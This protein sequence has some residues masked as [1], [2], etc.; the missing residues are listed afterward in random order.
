MMADNLFI[1]FD[2]F[3]NFFSTSER[4]LLP[5]ANQFKTYD[6]MTFQE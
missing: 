1:A 2:N 6:K 3:D 4:K 5:V